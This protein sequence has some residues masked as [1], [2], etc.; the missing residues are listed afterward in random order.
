LRQELKHFSFASSNW[1]HV[2]RE[3][4]R[5]FRKHHFMVALTFRLRRRPGI[6][7][8]ESDDAASTLWKHIGHDCAYF[9]SV[10]PVQFANRL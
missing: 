7:D 5:D 8:L 9:S 6:D 1:I 10:P 4:N 2:G 3:K